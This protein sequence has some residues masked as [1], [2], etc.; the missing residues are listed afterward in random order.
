MALLTIFSGCLKSS[1]P[2]LGTW[3]NSTMGPETT[4]EIK[5]EGNGY[6]LTYIGTEMDD[7]LKWVSSKP[8]TVPAI[9][10]TDLLIAGAIQAKYDKTNDVLIVGQLTFLRKEKK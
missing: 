2:F 10:K 6:N 5:K 9:I 8:Q 1:N 7:K 3:T 4:I